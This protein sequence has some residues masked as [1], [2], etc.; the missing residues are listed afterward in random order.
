MREIGTDMHAAAS[1]LAVVARDAALKS[2]LAAAL[3]GRSQVMDQCAAC[4]SAFRVHQ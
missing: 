4:R 3:A 1:R 2:D